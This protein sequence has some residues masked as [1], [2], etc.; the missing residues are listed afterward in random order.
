M[1]NYLKR[2][3]QLQN[4]LPDC[5]PATRAVRSGSIAGREQEHN[6]AIYATSSFAFGSAAEA[7]GTFLGET[8]DL[9]EGSGNIYS[10]FTNPTVYTFEKRIA[11]ME[12]AEQAVAASSGMGA[13]TSIF[14]GHLQQGDHVVS[15]NRIFGS[16]SGLF[17]KIIS[18]F[19]VQITYVNPTDKKAWQ[20]AIQANTKMLFAETPSNPL[21]EIVDIT[22]LADLAHSH[23]ALLIID[24]CV[25]TPVLQQPLALGADIVMHSATK[26]IDGQ[27]RC[28]GGVALGSEALMEPVFD[29]LRTA[30][31]CLSPFHAWVY[32]NGLETLAL[33]M[34]AHCDGAMQ[35]AQWL[36]QHHKVGR[37][38]YPGL[39][40]HT[41]HE[42][43][44]QQQS[45]FGAML[46]FELVGNKDTA[47]QCIDATRLLS[48]T[49]NFGDAKST[50]THPATTTHGRLQASVRQAAGI[51]DNLIRLSIGLEAVDD[52]IADLDQALGSLS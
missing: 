45:H 22:Y 29:F 26:Y 11:A 44:K 7:A 49:G 42:L 5:D 43:A 12:G 37:V 25:C 15:S 39:V 14:L 18:K 41:G 46:S 52:I 27:G 1:M 32:I 35:V 13:L 30:G 31:T 51:N 48:I 17:D 47:W 20:Q 23:A 4:I 16:I 40:N 33:R 9:A 6:D 21:G 34:Q 28:V 2:Q 38:F 36:S 8:T 24:N 3:Q 50:I 19:G 10:R